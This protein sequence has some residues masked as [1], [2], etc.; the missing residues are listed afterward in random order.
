MRNYRKLGIRGIYWE[1][2][3]SW[4]PQGLDYYMTARLAWNP[5]MDLEKEL[6]L[7]YKNYYGPAAKPMKAYHELW[8]KALEKHTYP[9]Q[10][11]GRGMYL[12]CS[13]ALINQLGK[14]MESAQ[15]LVKG[16]P[17]YE[18]RL[19]GVW[20]GYEFSRRIS[21]ILVLKKKYGKIVVEA[22]PG[23]PRPPDLVGPVFAGTGS[24]YQSEEAE[25]AYG[26]LIRWMRSVNTEDQVFDMHLNPKED[27]AE[28]IFPQSRD[29]DVYGS[30]FFAYLPVDLLRNEL[31][32]NDREEVLL[33]DF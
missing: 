14:Q 21:E 10:S 12:V 22:P 18:R 5:D 1:S 23:T 2:V 26:D 17:L 7:Y 30:C 15:A 19:K 16:Q 4:G 32:P 33:K 27:V 3:M 29:A 31:Y 6:N 9:V 20:A 28:T 11:G 13:P 24:Y 8:M 25:K